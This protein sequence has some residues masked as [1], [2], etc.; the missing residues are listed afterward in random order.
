M[1]GLSLCLAFISASGLANFAAD[2]QTPAEALYADLQKLPPAERQARLETG[3]RK[4]GK[5][6]IIN[7]MREQNQ[8]QKAMFN[9]LYPDIIVEMTNDL[10]SQ[11]AV[12]QLYAE[13]TAGRHLTDEIVVAL[14]DLAE[15][16][17]KDMLA[18]FPTPVAKAILPQYR[19]F[20]DPQSRWLPFYWSQYGI[21][22]N[23]NLVPP[24]KAPKA[25]LDLCNP[26]FKGNV[27]FDPAEN[28]FIAGLASMLGEKA[29]E[30]YFK[31]LGANDPII[32]RGHDQ[33]MHL[34]LAGDHMVLGDAY[35]DTGLKIK[36]SN[37][38]APFGM[39]LSAPILAIT[40]LVAINRNV[41]HPY[42]AALFAEWLMSPKSQKFLASDLRGP[43]AL[44]HPFLPDD[45]TIVTTVN[46][47]PDE[48]KR[49]IGDW[50]KYM[51]RKG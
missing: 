13:E 43:V 42:A 16:L 35:L 30:D 17:Q 19:G 26:F 2:A 48:M 12:E 10:G 21:S 20:I 29:T 4:E 24:D 38:G 34:M 15:L 27:S 22:Y 49:L 28:R 8:A 7:T 1:R 3:A 6:V 32:Q 5:L 9:K 46:P 33:R 36:R 25:W 14:P 51:D 39:V 18:R 45:A 37:P 23:T 44:K 40:G 47:P 31:C 11:D 50:H 41:Q